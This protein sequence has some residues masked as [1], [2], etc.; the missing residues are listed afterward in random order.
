MR[1]LR[2]VFFMTCMIMFASVF[3]FSRNVDASQLKQ[4]GQ[5][6]NS[7]AISWEGLD[8]DEGQVDSYHVYLGED[9][10]SA[11][12]AEDRVDCAADV[13]SYTFTDLKAGKRYYARVTCDYKVVKEEE[14]ESQIIYD[15]QVAYGFIRTNAGVIENLKQ[16]RW[17]PDA[18]E[19][20]FDWDKQT[21]ADGYECILKNANGKILKKWEVTANIAYCEVSSSQIYKVSVRSYTIIDGRKKWGKS[22]ETF[23]IVQ[24]K[25]NG[26]TKVSEGK[27]TIKWN[28]MKG[29]SSYDVY[30]SSQEKTGFVKVKRV[31]G[32]THKL[33]L[34]KFK[35]KK[36]TKN[37]K[38][39]IYIAANK[40][41][42][43][44][45]FSSFKKYTYRIKGK[46]GYRKDSF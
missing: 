14:E 24:P 39:Y 1:N 40:K 43:K 33:I 19:V 32:K 23:L 35:N 31:S 27:L 20:S 3:I 41:V 16:K 6:Q 8:P 44:K 26:G 46:K 9:Y 7:I 25:C 22:A 38:F 11:C 5:S 34:K 13:T 17:Y 42:G 21:G 18:D 4:T 29:V 36:I 28:K 37:N 12:I 30:V 2:N 15:H 10:S 45:T